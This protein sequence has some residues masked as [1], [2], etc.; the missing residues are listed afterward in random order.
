MGLSIG[1]L[2]SGLDTQS[3]ISQLMTAEA[4]PQNALKGKLSVNTVKSGAWTSLGTIV[5]GLQDKATALSVPGGL[6]AAA[7]TTNATTQVALKT[8]ATA[9]PGS[10]TFRINALASAQQL[11]T[12]PLAG[13]T[14]VVGRTSTVLSAGHDLVGATAVTAGADAVTGHRT[15][16]VGSSASSATVSGTL[17][18]AAPA[19][20]TTLDVTAGGTTTSIDLTGAPTDPA[21]LVG[22]LQAQLDAGGTAAKV[23]RSGSSLVLRSTATG[24]AATLTV[25]GTGAAALGLSAGQVHG[26]DVTVLV[27]GV[28]AGLTDD[29]AG[30]RLLTLS[31]G[32][33]VQFADGPKVGTLS[34]GLAVTTSDTSTMGDLASALA[35]AGGPARGALVDTGS[36]TDPYRL[37]LSASGTGA[38]GAL[39]I[40]STVA[41]LT[42]TTELRPAQ[43]AEVVLGTGAD[44]LTLHRSSNTITDLLPGVTIDLTKADPATDVTVQVSRDDA[45][46]AK[47]VRGLV[48]SLNDTLAWIRT[49]TKYDVATSKGGPMVGDGSVRELSSQLTNAMFTSATTGTLSI[50]AQIGITLDRD[51]VYQFDETAFTAALTSDPESVAGVVNAV[52]GAV[53][54]V[55]KA[56]TATSGVVDVGKAST[57]AAAKDLQTRIDDWDDKLLAINNRYQRVFS[58][59]DVALQKM[60]SQKSWLSSQI[61]ALG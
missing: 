31:D 20:G 8:S 11:T 27:D 30:G 22:F 4:G 34:I 41:D 36:G 55:A 51:G 13:P 19:A 44:A 15:V 49:N 29:P 18:T 14:T 26:D 10:L 42:S 45:A 9:V 53:S 5:K 28:P 25:G 59:L 56:A 52:A 6:A 50:G 17:P 60:N 33:T 24:A 43:D 46:V 47:Q 54:T 57:A 12:G 7:A 40:S 61:D 3:I 1:G 16:V 2:G 35:S 37:V 48:D 58:S 23:E 38:A 21:A 39:R 32:T